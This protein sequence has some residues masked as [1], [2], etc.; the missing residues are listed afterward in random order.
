MRTTAAVACHWTTA[1]LAAAS[2][3]CQAHQQPCKF[4]WLCAD[5]LRDN[6]SWLDA[7]IVWITATM[8]PTWLER[9]AALATLLQRLK[10]GARICLCTH[11]LDGLPGLRRTAVVR[12]L[13]TSWGVDLG[14]VYERFDVDKEDEA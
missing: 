4:T 14:F 3:L 11:Q 12:D 8:F 13:K 6:D 2:S 10:V 1:A 5:F 9:G 7:D